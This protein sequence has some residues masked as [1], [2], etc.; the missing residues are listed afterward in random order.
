MRTCSRSNG[1]SI[2]Y[3]VKNT[4]SN[5]V[6]LPIVVVHIAVS[7]DMIP[8]QQVIARCNMAGVVAREHISF[9]MLYI[10]NYISSVQGNVAFRQQRM[11][12]RRLRP[13]FCHAL[14]AVHN[15]QH[16]NECTKHTLSQTSPLKKCTHQH[17]SNG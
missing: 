3:C 4:G 10:S 16:L 17:F 2:H 15:S 5:W 9:I 14:G 11:R 1:Y 13:T 7:A 8:W 12:Q 6:W